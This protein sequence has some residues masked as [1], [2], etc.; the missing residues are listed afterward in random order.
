MR[1]ASVASHA[2]PPRVR[3]SDDSDEKQKEKKTKVTG[4]KKA[5]KKAPKKKTK[6]DENEDEDVEGDCCPLIDRDDEDDDDNL[7]SDEEAPTH[8]KGTAKKR[9]AS[10]RTRKKTAPTSKSKGRKKAIKMDDIFRTLSF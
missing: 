5:P 4:T 7:D 2:L 1:G 9:P 6:E 10:A 3:D 8:P